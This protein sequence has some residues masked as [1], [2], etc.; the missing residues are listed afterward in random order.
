MIRA[1]IWSRT[2]TLFLRLRR[3]LAAWG[4][5]DVQLLRARHPAELALAGALDLAVLAPD[6]PAR[7]GAGAIAAKTLLIPEPAWPLVSLLS[8][9][10][11][12]SYG[13]GPRNTLTLSSLETGRLGVA[14]QRAMSTV[15]GALLEQQEFFVPLAPEESPPEAL[16][17]VGALL[18]LDLPPE[19]LAREMPGGV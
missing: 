12:V 17:L 1:G 11:A 4:R 8:A 10:E 15:S 5:A 2:E 3:A 9:A 13:P 6:A 18:L 7:A 19:K 16:A 14:L